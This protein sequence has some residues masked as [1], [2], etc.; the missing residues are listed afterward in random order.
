MN[1]LNTVAKMAINGG[2]SFLGVEWKAAVPLTAK[3][4]DGLTRM[5]SEP[6]GYRKETGRGRR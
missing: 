4:V 6:G 5:R 2:A 3:A 1:T